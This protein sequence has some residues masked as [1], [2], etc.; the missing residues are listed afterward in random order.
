MVASA[1]D[2]QTLHRAGPENYRERLA[3]LRPGDTLV[4][5]AREYRAGLPLHNLSGTPG[6]PITISGP[7][8]GAPAGFLARMGATR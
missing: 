4:L 5:A 2:A 3:L 6:R 8:R 7:A 1:A